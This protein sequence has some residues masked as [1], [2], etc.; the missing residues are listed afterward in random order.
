[1]RIIDISILIFV[2]LES[3]NVYV[4]YFAPDFKYGNGIAVFNHWQDSKQDEDAHLFAKYLVNWVAG[5]KLIFILL[6]FVVLFKANDVTKLWAV[7]ATIAAI[8]TYYWRLHPII[9]ALDSKGHI[10]P[11]GYSKTLGHTIAGF[12]LMFSAALLVGTLQVLKPF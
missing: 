9:K 10:T 6:L 4:L 2:I 11:K 12:L 7:A 8:A 3:A 1:M 5:T